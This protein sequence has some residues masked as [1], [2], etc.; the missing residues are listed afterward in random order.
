MTDL[1][2]VEPDWLDRTLV[3]HE[4]AYRPDHAR[5][6]S[7]AEWTE[8]ILTNIANPSMFGATP[9][10][11]PM[12]GE[13]ARLRAVDP[14]INNLG[15]EMVLF[16]AGLASGGSLPAA[17]RALPYAGRFAQQ[18][19]LSM[20]GLTAEAERKLTALARS[21]QDRLGR[22]PSARELLDAIDPAQLAVEAISD[23][24][25]GSS[26]QPEDAASWQPSDSLW[27]VDALGQAV[28]RPRQGFSRAA[29]ATAQ[30]IE[31]G[32][33]LRWIVTEAQERA[34]KEY[35]KLR[36][37]GGR[38][39][40]TYTKRHLIDDDVYA[41][42]TSGIYSPQRNV[43]QRSWANYPSPDYHDPILDKSSVLYSAIRGREQQLI[44][45]YRAM[46][47]SDNVFNG[48]HRWNPLRS[49]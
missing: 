1:N 18:R 49:Y 25:S 34:G 47:I 17:I 46:G 37:A 12:A 33:L 20:R 14:P 27:A 15:D 23:G 44:D 36:G 13:I 11:D 41:G 31:L 3:D 30:D 21:F 2:L 6:T 4:D 42:R 35:D 16:A 7:D 39:F 19:L 26:A 9:D 29:T 28:L 5:P 38:S 24:L 45:H 43:K 8:R 32:K 10:T 22:M 40:Q 48:I